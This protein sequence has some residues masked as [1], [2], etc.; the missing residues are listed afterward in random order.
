[1]IALPVT[2]SVSRYRNMLIFAVNVLAVKIWLVTVPSRLP[3]YIVSKGVVYT[4]YV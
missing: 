2:I 1:M 4:L 3:L